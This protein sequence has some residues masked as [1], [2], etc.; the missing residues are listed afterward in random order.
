MGVD[1]PGMRRGVAQEIR[2][3]IDF[4]ALGSAL[5]RKRRWIFVPALLVA[6]MSLVAVNVVTPKYRS[7]SRILIEGRENAFLR[8]EAEKAMDRTLIDQEAV[9]SQVQILMSRDL[10]A[11]VIRELKLGDKPEFDPVVNGAPIS[12]VL[13]SLFG[14]AKDPLRMSPEE[15]VLQSYFDRLSVVP[16]DKSRVISVEFQ[17]SDPALAAQVVNTIGDAYLAFQ[18]TAKQQQTRSA[19]VWLAGEIDKMRS[20][21]EEA[22]RKVEEFRSRA[23]LY[24]GTN[25]AS[26]ANQQLS[27]L[28]TQLA[29][30]RAQKAELDAK[31]RLIRDML[32]SGKPVESADVMNSEL[33]RRLIEQRVT[34]RAQLAEQSSTLLSLHPRI[35]ELNAQINALDAQ[36]RGELEK[37]ARS[38][39]NDARIA[40][41]RV[42]QTVTALDQLKRTIAASSGQD[43]D[44]RALEREAKA[45]RDLLESYLAKYREAT[46]RDSVGAAP[47]DARIISRA[48][49]SNVPIFPKKLPIVLIATLATMVLSATVI[50]TGEMIGGGASIP[51]MVPAAVPAAAMPKSRFGF[52]RRSGKQRDAGPATG[53]AAPEISA[54]SPGM[55]I[56]DLARTLRSLGDAA[57]RI[58]VIGTARNVGT[59]YTAIGLARLLASSSRVVLVDLALNAPN[60]SV[61]STNPGAPGIAELVRGAATF[62]EVI[63][64]DRFSRTHLIAAGKSAGDD[65]ALLASPRLAATL[66]A[67][68]RSYDH[69]VVDAGAISDVAVASF[70]KIAPRAV[71]VA[72]DARHPDTLAA[73]QRMIGAG[74]T[75]VTVFVNTRRPGDSATVA[76]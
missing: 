34:L 20:K 33:L 65:A 10:A 40:G 4:A 49:V 69:V 15:R 27:D 6:A 52:M 74:F 67:L 41:A 9:A 42:D 58:T 70:A 63:T 68:A 37:L 61:M 11:Q 75:D 22:D 7:E 2:A 18:Q 17:S 64:R 72:L 12:G 45:Q 19:S 62:G 23:N 55:P 25:N 43:V 30:A 66:E 51:V 59:T 50:V 21:V 3:D 57:R 73:R 29:S 5:W 13:L 26:L 76:A 56:G 53:V 14:L 38:I 54:E 44:L 46:A 35:L 39:E 47:A 32:K 36:I 48:S 24:V 1:G 16:V 31:S 28:T 60:I 71:L 8:P